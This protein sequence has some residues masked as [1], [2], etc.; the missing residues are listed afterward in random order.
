MSEDRRISMRL[1]RI[2]NTLEEIKRSI[3]EPE[4]PD[5][6]ITVNAAA[7]AAR[8]REN[9]QQAIAVLD[10]LTATQSTD[11]VEQTSAIEQSAQT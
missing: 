9:Q 11:T 1:M 8:E 4:P 3:T 2:E 6:M 5:R 10:T 7:D